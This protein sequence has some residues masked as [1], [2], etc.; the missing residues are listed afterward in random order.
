MRCEA[1]RHPLLLSSRMSH[2]A[3]NGPYPTRLRDGVEL[4]DHDDWDC[5][6]DC[7]AAGLLEMQGLPEGYLDVEPGK[8]GK[9]YPQLKR[10]K[11][12]LGYEWDGHPKVR[13]TEEG[14]QAAAA[15][16]A[17]KANGGQFSDF[18]WPQP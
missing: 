14:I 15:L 10:R 9:I 12:S 6:A 13:L 16:R 18:A 4:Q 3:N 7:V 1:Q 2:V 11:N 8:R 17:H 5:L